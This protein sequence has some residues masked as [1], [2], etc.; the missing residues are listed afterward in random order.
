[1]LTVYQPSSVD[2]V[3]AEV[4]DALY[5]ITK[6]GRFL[7]KYLDLSAYEMFVVRTDQAVMI[8]QLFGSHLSFRP[9][10]S[11]DAAN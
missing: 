9:D 6:Y 4:L 2:H 3:N 7:I 1:M 5:R 8:A 10:N 11:V